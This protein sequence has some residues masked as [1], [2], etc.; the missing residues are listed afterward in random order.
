MQ[1]NEAVATPENLPEEMKLKLKNAIREMSDSYVRVEAERDLQKAILETVS[2][3]I[4]VEKKIIR[5]M[6]RAFHK[7]D[8]DKLR[9][10]NQTFE[11][12]YESV[13]GRGL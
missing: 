11:V 2:E 8:F 12:S 10:E 4:G 13:F 9:E 6:A 1:N 5:K 7:Q 3:E